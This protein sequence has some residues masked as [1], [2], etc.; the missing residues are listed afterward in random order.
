LRQRRIFFFRDAIVRRDPFA[1][2]VVFLLGP[3]LA[4]PS[5]HPQA[6]HP[7]CRWA[8]ASLTH[9]QITGLL[10]PDRRSKEEGGPLGGMINGHLVIV[11]GQR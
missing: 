9:D 4:L 11:L 3:V 5:T 7:L 6:S 2:V 1:P 8:Y 10:T